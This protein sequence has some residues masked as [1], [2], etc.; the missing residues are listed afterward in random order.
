MSDL[1]KSALPDAQSEGSVAIREAGL[2]VPITI[3]TTR[4]AV[5]AVALAGAVADGGG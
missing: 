5:A 3:D 4:A 2:A 1:A